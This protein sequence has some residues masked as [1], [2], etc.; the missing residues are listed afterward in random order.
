MPNEPTLSLADRIARAQAVAAAR[1]P[2]AAPAPAPAVAA[3]PAAPVA[4][5]ASMPTKAM[6]RQQRVIWD[7]VRAAQLNGAKDLTNRE[8]LERWRLQGPGSKEVPTVS[9][10][11]SELLDNHWLLRREHRRA[12]GVTAELAWCVYVPPGLLHA[13][14]SQAVK[15]HGL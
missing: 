3:A 5:T 9:G 2:A 12:C 8:I 7:I 1:R 15:A 14:P 4:A 11:V 10:R 6:R 13:D